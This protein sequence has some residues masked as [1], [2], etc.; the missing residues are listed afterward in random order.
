VEEPA[1]GTKLGGGKDDEEIEDGEVEVEDVDDEE[2]A[3]GSKVG[4][5]EK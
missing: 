3:T 1:S 2:D 5:D 4:G